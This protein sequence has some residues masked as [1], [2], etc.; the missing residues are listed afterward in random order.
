M[1]KS[2]SQRCQVIVATQ[3]VEL[4][5]H[6]DAEDIIA[7]DRK[8]RTEGTTFKRFNNQDLSEWLE[9]YSIGE[10]WEKNLIGGR[11]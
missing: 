2:A 5:N 3:S 10:I 1:L 9:E 4:V 11:P 6:F 8:N 7:V